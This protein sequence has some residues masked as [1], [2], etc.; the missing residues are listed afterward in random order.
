MYKQ[1]STS[2]FLY[3]IQFL[4]VAIY[5]FFEDFIWRFIAKPIYDKIKSLKPFQKLQYLIGKLDKY[6]TI[7]LFIILFLSV[8]SCGFLAGI[9]FLEGNISLAIILYLIKLQL[10]TFTFWLFRVSKNKL[11]TFSWFAWG[12][13]LILSILDRIKGMDVYINIVSIFKNLKLKITSFRVWFRI[14]KGSFIEDIKN[15]YFYLK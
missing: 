9:F 15:I 7:F 14:K 10:A 3:L 11:L 4:L 13:T 6:S 8:E 12:Y 5:I 1:S 2:R